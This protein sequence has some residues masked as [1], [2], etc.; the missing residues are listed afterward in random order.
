MRWFGRVIYAFGIATG[1]AA[2]VE[3][4]FQPVNAIVAGVLVGVG[5]TTGWTE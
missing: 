2:M 5:A 3:P 1:A 4:G